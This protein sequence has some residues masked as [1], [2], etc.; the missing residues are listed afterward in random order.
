MTLGGGSGVD[1]EIHCIAQYAFLYSELERRAKEGKRLAYVSNYEARLAG[2][3]K[4]GDF[5]LSTEYSFEWASQIW[6]GVLIRAGGYLHIPGYKT[7]IADVNGDDRTIIAFGRYFTSNPDLP[8]RLK[9]GYP[10]TP[11]DRSKFYAPGE[12]GYNTFT[13]YVVLSWRRKLLQ[14]IFHFFRSKN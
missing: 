5:G 11:Y 3:T 14:Y 9:N 1:G 4:D 8:S 12:D 7:L 2:F 13:N 10:L 6:T